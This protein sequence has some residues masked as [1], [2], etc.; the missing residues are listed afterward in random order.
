MRV[1][2]A[3]DFYRSSAPS[4]EDAVFRNE[5]RLLGVNG[6]EVIPFERFNDKIDDSTF[7][8]RMGLALDGSW[9]RSTYGD[10]TRIIRERRPDVAHFHNTFPLISPS[11]YAACQDNGVPVVQTLH[12]YRLICPGALL[13]RNGKPCEDCVGASL[14]PALRHRCYRGSLSAT[15]ALVWMIASNR[16][17][18]TYN[19]LVNRYVALTRFSASKL[20]AGG[21]PHDRME[22]KPNFLFDVP[23]PGNG[24]GGYA[25]YV[26]RLSEEKGVETLL[27]AW[28]NNPNLPLK[29]LGDGP[30]RA[31]LQ[32]RAYDEGLG[33]EFLGFR[34]REEI[35]DIVGQAVLQI[36]PSQW[37]EGFPMVILE[38]YACGTPVVASRIGSLNEIVI[39]NE[40]GLK[41]EP[42][43]AEDLAAK[44]NA[45]FT[46]PDRLKLFRHNA[47][48]VFEKHYT[49]ER[50]FIQLMDIY[51]HAIEDFNSCTQMQ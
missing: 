38:A 12:N 30:L 15:T 19:K 36:V 33:V 27:T 20:V 17:R 42:G 48:A 16:T 49:A 41:F 2:L 51:R 44:V 50:N 35:L 25:V 22:V 46:N 4:G 39:E 18:G 21:L 31:A 26:G 40:T 23:E 13:L 45:L 28:G 3:H 34:S 1:L 37:Y 43:N 24:D 7:A 8:K 29:I 32:K 5:C 11:A 6:I 9:S 10:L 14:L 47:R